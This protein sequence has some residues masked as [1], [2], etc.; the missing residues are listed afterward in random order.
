VL[1]TLA[2]VMRD[3]VVVVLQ[4]GAAVS[5]PEAVARVDGA[6]SV[7]REHWQHHPGPHPALPA[8]GSERPAAWWAG[9][10][11]GQGG[12]SESPQLCWAAGRG[13]Q[14]AGHMRP[15]TGPESALHILATVP[16]QLAYAV[17]ARLWQGPGCRT[18]RQSLLRPCEGNGSEESCDTPGGGASERPTSL[19]GLWPSCKGTRQEL[20]RSFAH[21]LPRATGPNQQASCGLLPLLDV[22]RAR[23]HALWAVSACASSLLAMSEEGWRSGGRPTSH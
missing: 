6:C 2:G 12:G 7:M 18:T 4:N 1:S 10:G 8:S 14:P 15:G 21:K 17:Q 16:L 13:L 20:P 9:Q 3:L 19:S 11:Q 5:Y 23:E 22:W